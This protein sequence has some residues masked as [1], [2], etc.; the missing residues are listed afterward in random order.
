M[1]DSDPEGK[2]KDVED[3]KVVVILTTLTTDSSNH[4]PRT[5][6]CYLY[7]RIP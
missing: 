7:N 5:R 4:I 6:R 2:K 1:I 3:P